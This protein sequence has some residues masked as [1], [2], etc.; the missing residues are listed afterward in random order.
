M[1]TYSHSQLS[2]Y[3]TC[4]YQYKLS[5]IQ[6][7]KIDTEGIEA[8]MGSRVH[9]V[10]EKLYRDLKMTK[11]NTLEELLEFY[12]QCWEKNWTEAVQIIRKEYSAEDY[13]SLGAKCITEYY[14]RYYPFDQGKTLGLEE[15]IYFPLEEEKGYWIRGVIDRLTL[16]NGSVLEIHDYK[17][18]GRLPT[19]K[20]IQSDRQLAFYHMGVEGKWK[21]IQ[22]IKL[23]WHYLVFDAEVQSQRTP[24]DLQQLRQETLELIKKIES[25]REFIPKESPLCDWCDYQ[26]L[27]PKRRHRVVTEN[28][29]PNEYLNEEGVNLV[30]KYVEL[31]EKKGILTGEIDAEIARVEEALLAYAEQKEL[32]AI[33]GSDHVAKI[34]TEAKEKYP[35]KGEPSRRALDEFIKNAGKWM[36]VSDLNPWMLARILERGGWPPSLAKKVKEFATVEKNRTITLSKLKERD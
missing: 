4:P 29:P 36:E 28:L 2:T 9:D 15:T 19:Q 8:F 18:S 33:F 14:K 11:L 35:L 27:C 32:G 1:P 10:L 34:K 16:L 30:N 6:K 21:D 12:H 23:I 26:G 17:T 22:E 31:K 5:Y 3:E 25:D 13:R 24:E 20:D 7:I